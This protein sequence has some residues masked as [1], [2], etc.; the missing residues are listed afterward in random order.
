MEPDIAP[1]AKRL[2]EENNVNWRGLAGSG[3]DGRILEKDVLEYLARVMS[4]EEDL[5]PTAEPVPEGME[6][7]P[8][9]DVHAYKAEMGAADTSAESPEWSVAASTSPAVEENIVADDDDLFDLDDAPVEVSASGGAVAVSDDDLDEDIF[10]FGEE[11]PARTVEAASP[12]MT[13]VLPIPPENMQIDANAL[14][15]GDYS[16]DYAGLDDSDDVFSKDED[17]PV[18]SEAAASETEFDLADVVAALESE[19]DALDDVATA[20]VDA[21]GFADAFA[22]DANEAIAQDI[23]LDTDDDLAADLDDDI[24]ASSDLDDEELDFDEDVASLFVDD[25]AIGEVTASAVDA[26]QDEADDDIFSADAQQAMSEPEAAL[27]DDFETETVNFEADEMEPP[28]FVADEAEAAAWTEAYQAD[29]ELEV[30]AD[31]PVFE[32]SSAA[33]AAVTE[34]LPADETETDISDDFVKGGVVAATAAAAAGFVADQSADADG[35]QAIP[36]V[37][38]GTLLRRHVDVTA[39]LQAQTDLSQVMHEDI[40]LGALLLR[41]T[42]R[43]LENSSWT[44]EG[45]LGLAMIDDDGIH[46]QSSAGKS[47]FRKMLRNLEPAQ[48]ADLGLIVADMSALDIDEAVLNLDAPVLA[49]GRTLYDSTK[50]SSRSSL[51]LSGDVPVEAGAKLLAA[52]AELL[53]APIKLVV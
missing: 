5:N 36:L 27:A 24:F 4:G 9:E 13:E 29:A 35:E 46:L 23:S 37:S 48:S 12:A 3:S 30:L 6:A 50:G 11:E 51:S 26:S 17:L 42:E 14:V 16:E 32:E 22:D 39:L 33:V 45:R 2:A 40:A 31:E 49:L 15:N 52:I 38:Y 8:E 1:L 28:A 47:G 53:D 21:D 25:V 18:F 34:G 20:A 10:L 41:A 19:P 43:A 7:W 44:L